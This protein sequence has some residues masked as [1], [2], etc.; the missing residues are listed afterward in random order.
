MRLKRVSQQNKI[1]EPLSKT[2]HIAYEQLLYQDVKQLQR[3]NRAR[4]INERAKPYRVRKTIS[5][6]PVYVDPVCKYIQYM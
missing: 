6:P 3:D 5:P 4:L 2:K 1:I